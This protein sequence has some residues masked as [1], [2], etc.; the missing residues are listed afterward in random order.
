MSNDIHTDPARRHDFVL[1]FDVEN[2]NPNG[3]PDAG[4]LPRIDPETMHGIITDV[5][6]KR[7]VRDYLQ[8]TK[9]IPI[10]I[11][12]E[13]ALNTLI[14]RA[15]RDVG[16]EFPQIVIAED[17][18][19]DVVQWFSENDPFEVN[20]NS[21]LYYGDSF[22][23]K[24]IEKHF[25]E[26]VDAVLKAKL[27]PYAKQLSDSVKKKTLNET[28]REKTKQHLIKERFDIRMFGAVLST[29]LNA[30]QVRGPVQFTFAKSVD[31]IFRLDNAITRKAITKE[32]DKRIKD[33]EMARKPTVPYA[34]YQAHGFYNPYFALKPKFKKEEPDEMNTWF[35][36]MILAIYGRPWNGCST[37]TLL[38][39]VVKWQQGGCMY[40]LT[41]VREVTHHH[42]NFSNEFLFPK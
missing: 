23:Q 8:I 37:T 34:L 41:T 17:I 24:N 22:K 21:L 3:D 25:D 28:D 11:Q 40:L 36:K 7:K 33:T 42:I 16:A 32:S 12:S 10:F 4:N 14:S 27:K 1:L 20:N 6:L 29:G 19:D 30:G 2:G 26:V 39:L 5:C 18:D 13:T 15:A 9:N 31:P 35:Q 38:P